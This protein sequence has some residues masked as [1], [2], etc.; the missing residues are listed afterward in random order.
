[1]SRHVQQALTRGTHGGIG[2]PTCRDNRIEIVGRD[3][4]H[5]VTGTLLRGRGNSCKTESGLVNDNVASVEV[6]ADEVYDAARSSY[7]TSATTGDRHRCRGKGAGN[8]APM[9]RGPH[10]Y[11]GSGPLPM[12]RRSRAQS[13]RDRARSDWP[14]CFADK[15]FPD[16]RMGYVPA[17]GGVAGRVI[18]G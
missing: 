18:G 11:Q 17:R 13:T 8:G 3:P 10:A 2:L 16:R 5:Q 7:R 9:A 15:E 6:A 1:M 12:P 4:R 14:G